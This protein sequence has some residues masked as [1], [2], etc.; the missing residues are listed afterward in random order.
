M[1]PAGVGRGASRKLMPE[2]R[3]DLVWWLNPLQQSLAEAPLCQALD[4]LRV[5]LNRRF[6]LGLKRF[7]GHFAVYPRGAN[8]HKHI[9]QFRNSGHRRVSFVLYLNPDWEPHWGGALRLYEPESPDTVALEVHPRW[10]RLVVFFSDS[11][12]HEVLATQKPRFSF[13]GWFRDD[14]EEAVSGAGR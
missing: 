14:D 7:E 1:Q 13:T 2:V 3:S 8:Y 12:P 5:Q 6:F 11:V 9:D 4:E 10:G